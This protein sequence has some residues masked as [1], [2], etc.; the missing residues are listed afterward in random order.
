MKQKGQQVR[1]TA[2]AINAKGPEIGWHIACVLSASD[3]SY[4]H[5]LMLT[6]YLIEPRHKPNVSKQLEK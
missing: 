4:L 6:D 5:L 2:A 1:L 3:D